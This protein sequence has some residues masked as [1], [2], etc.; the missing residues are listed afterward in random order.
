M[1]QLRTEIPASK[2]TDSSGPRHDLDWVRV[3]VFGLLIQYNVGMIFV[4]WN[5][6]FKN[7]TIAEFRLCLTQAFDVLNRG[8]V[9]I[10]LIGQ[11]CKSKVHWKPA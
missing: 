5:F 6:H 8:G 9:P 4:P 7:E 3:I 1:S 11:S 2:V 10:Y